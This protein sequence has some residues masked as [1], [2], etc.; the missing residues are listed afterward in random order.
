MEAAGFSEKM[1]SAYFIKL[2]GK[3]QYPNMKNY[4]P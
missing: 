2:Y 1:L 3:P 4:Q